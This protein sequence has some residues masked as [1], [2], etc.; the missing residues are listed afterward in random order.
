MELIQKRKEILKEREER[1]MD[2]NKLDSVTK[3][4]NGVW[5]PIRHEGSRTGIEICIKGVD[6]KEFKT[7]SLSIRKY[8]HQQEKKKEEADV[9]ITQEKMIE[10]IAGITINWRDVSEEGVALKVD[11]SG[12]ILNGEVLKFNIEN[13]ITL[14]TTLPFIAEQIA[15]ASADRNLFLGV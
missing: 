8:I 11:K 14:Y 9:E 1:E 13:A 6:S 4:E 15:S 3:S 2:L 12:L 7:R 10:L 5:I